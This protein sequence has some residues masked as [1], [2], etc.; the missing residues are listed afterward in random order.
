MIVWG[1][2]SSVFWAIA[3]VMFLWV[4]CAFVGRFV[5]QSY[6]M[7]TVLHLV[8]FVV[9]VPTVVLF[10]AFFTCG[11]VN[12]IVNR[13]DASI[14][15]ILMTD[16]KFVE[17]LQRQISQASQTADVD[18]LTDFIA[19]NFS[20]KIASEYPMLKK[21]MNENQILDNM[22]LSKQISNISQGANAVEGTQQL[23]Q[24]SVSGFTKG[25]KA[26]VKSTRRKMLITVILLQAIPFGVTLYKAN[27]YRSAATSSYIYDT[28][29]Y[30]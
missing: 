4:L 15:K 22:D 17:Q 9:A 18:G 21:Y 23:V 1:I 27:S 20:D 28:D 6:R 26:K 10:F 14:V 8:C 25:I 2:I 19:D 5:N 11:K 30:L 3:G 16:G 12:R 7:T 29:N 13:V 24:A